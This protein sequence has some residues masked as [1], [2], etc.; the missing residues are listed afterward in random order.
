MKNLAYIGVLLTALL[1]TSCKQE[2]VS[3]LVPKA[4]FSL[5]NSYAIGE[6]KTAVAKFKAEAGVDTTQVKL[7]L[8]AG[9]YQATL[10]PINCYSSD[11]SFEIPEILSNKTGLCQWRLSFEDTPLGSGSFQV[12]PAD[13]SDYSI[14]TYIGPPSAKAGEVRA[15][16]AVAIP[17][18]A[19]DNLIR[20]S[21]SVQMDYR[22]LNQQTTTESTSIQEIRFAPQGL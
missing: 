9:V 8:E 21:D 13:S 5:A 15:A 19:H 20:K 2:Q 22:Y 12:V 6:L 4:E 1:V 14:N 18:D 17:R 16:M 11:C 10:S 7:F 3:P